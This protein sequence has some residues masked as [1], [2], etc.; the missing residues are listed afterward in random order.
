MQGTHAKAVMYR[1]L[2]EASLL[3]SPL[4]LVYREADC[5]GPT[6]TFI[7]LVREISANYGE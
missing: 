1:T 4:T 6:G 3:S 5:D 2:Q 7:A